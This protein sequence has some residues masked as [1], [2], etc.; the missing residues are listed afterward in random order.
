M[1][2]KVIKPT[3]Q[4]LELER[5]VLLHDIEILEALQDREDTMRQ[6]LKDIEYLLGGGEQR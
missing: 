4:A 5:E 1:D 2:A 3:R 6:R